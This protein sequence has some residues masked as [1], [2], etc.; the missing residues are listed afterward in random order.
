MRCPV[1]TACVDATCTACPGGTERVDCGA[2]Q[3]C[4]PPD[5][6]RDPCMAFVPAAT[7]VAGAGEE[8]DDSTP[9]HEV[10][11]TAGFWL[12]LVEVT[13]AQY[14]PC[15]DAGVCAS[16]GVLDPVLT[17]HL[18]AVWLGQEDAATFCAFRGDRLPTEAEW[19]LAARGTDDR[20][21]PWGM[22]AID[23]GRANYNKCGSNVRET[24]REPAGAGP[25]GHLDLAGNVSEWVS[26]LYGPYTAAPL[27]DPTGPLDGAKGVRRGG[28]FD[29]VDLTT[30]SYAREGTLR[31]YFDSTTGVRCVREAP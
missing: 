31:E 15:A 4:L 7:F 28:H 19:E 9:R 13:Q 18:P 20:I 25:F 3:A 27:F 23:C 30:S 21:Y 17:P 8:W 12:D 14:A 1:G 11:I 26:D 22:E 10:T 2:A 24:G 29:T 5:A 16:N 6:P